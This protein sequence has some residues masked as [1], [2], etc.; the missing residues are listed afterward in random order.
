MRLLLDTHVL[1]W[2]MADDSS[3]SPEVRATIGKAEVVY[4]S[5]VSIWE[6]SIK[7]SLGKLKIDQVRFMERLQ[8]AGFEPLNITWEHAAA[9]RHLPDIHRDPFD[10]MLIAQAVSEPL[11]LMTADKVLAQYSELVIPV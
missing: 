3:L 1:L 10:R 7:A 11:R 4:A 8:E 5:A 9:V 6:V 2:V